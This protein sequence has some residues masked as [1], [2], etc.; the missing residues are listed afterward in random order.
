[1]SLPIFE[2]PRLLGRH[3]S[4]DDL[5]AMLDVYGDAQVMRWVGDGR[6]LDREQCSRW[7]EITH[8]NYST[9]GYGMF[10]LVLRQSGGVIGFCGLVH[11]GGQ[12]EPE[13][14][15]A[16]L[17]A[18]WGRGFATEAARAVLD[19][20]AQVFH[21][22]QVTATAYPENTASHRV[23]VKAGMKAADSRRDEGNTIISVFAWQPGT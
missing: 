2:T 3:L 13:I 22:P 12:Q 8:K 5:E 4:P 14:K 19:Y 10:A 21:L 15:Y 17:P 7:I 20:G 11:P 1:M 16:L 6:P 9:Y 18:F 23:L